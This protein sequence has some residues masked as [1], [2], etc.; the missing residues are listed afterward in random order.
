MKG[1]DKALLHSEPIRA[2]FSATD[3]FII[4]TTNTSAASTTASTQ[5]TSKY[6]S[7]D[8][9][10]RR[11][12]RQRLQRELLRRDRI[13][14]LP[15]ERSGYLVQK[16]TRRHVERIEPFAK[17]QTMEL[18][19]TLLHRLGQRGAYAA[20]LIAQKAQQTDR[21]PRNATGVYR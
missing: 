16:A 18:V 17:T 21:R 19:T 5:N 4:N 15:Q 13:A 14:G 9:C 10:C 3:R 12:P 20:A 7:A 2:P 6:A 11:S 8:A 1:Q